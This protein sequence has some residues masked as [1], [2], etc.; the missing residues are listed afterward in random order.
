MNGRRHRSVR[1]VAKVSVRIT[2]QVRLA[3]MGLRFPRRYCPAIT[4]YSHLSVRELI[5]ASQFAG[6]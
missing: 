3:V 1:N 6:S 5:T 4:P 2:A